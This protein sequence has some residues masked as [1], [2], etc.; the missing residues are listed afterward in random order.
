[1]AATADLE[2]HPIVGGYTVA[3][4]HD[5]MVTDA[6]QFAVTALVESAAEAAPLYTGFKV[7]DAEKV[8]IGI[9][10]AETQ[11]RIVLG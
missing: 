8:K 4:R 2:G 9:V 1:L 3:N 10:S 7:E 11:V 6:A 5:A